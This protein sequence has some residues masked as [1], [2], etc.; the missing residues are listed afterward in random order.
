MENLLTLMNSLHEGGDSPAIIFLTKKGSQTWSFQ[1]LAS[2]SRRLARGLTKAG[3]SLGSHVILLAPN[4]PEWIVVACGLISAGI[5]PVPIDPQMGKEDLTHV[6][7]DSEAQWIFTTSFVLSILRSEQ[8]DQNRKIVLLDVESHHENS[9]QRFIAD[10][11]LPFSSVSSEDHAMLFYTSGTSGKPKGVPLTHGNL[12]SNL[13]ELLNLNLVQRNDRLLVPLP[14]HHVYPFTIGLLVSLATKI[15]LILPHSLTGPQL[16]RALREGNPTVMLG[17]PRLF[18]A[19]YSGIEKK[20]SQRGWFIA[21]GFHLALGLSI[22]LRRWFGLQFGRRIFS[23]LHREM[24]PGLQILVSGGSALSPELGWKLEGLGWRIGTGYGLTET[25]PILTL[26]KPGEGHLETA[27]TV[28]PGVDIKIAEPA[29][30][31]RHGEVLAKGPNV[32]SGYRHLPEKTREAFTNDGYFRTGDLAEWQGN[33]LKLVGRASS[34]IVLSGGENIRPDSIEEVLNEGSAI[35]ESG[36]L[37]KDDTLVALIVPATRHSTHDSR[38]GIAKQIE[39]D[40]HQHMRRLPSHHR[41]ADFAI[42]FDPLPRTRLGKLR[43]HKLAK[44]YEQAKQNKGVG[45][46]EKKGPM[47]IDQMSSEDQ[48]LVSDPQ[49]RHAWEWLS[50]RFHAIRLTPDSHVQMDLGVDSLEWVNLSVEIQDEIGVEMDQDTISR[51]E[52]VRDFLQAIAE[53]ETAGADDRLMHQL[54]DPHSLLDRTQRAWLAPLGSVERS[55]SHG[56]QKGNRW[57]MQT[58]YHVKAGG[59]EQL[60]KE[61]FILIANHVSFLDPLALAAVLPP[62]QLNNLYWAGWTEVM[63]RNFLMRGISRLAHVVPIDPQQGPFSNAAMGLACL[64]DGH[65]LGWF[66]EGRRSPDGKLQPFQSGI[67]VILEQHS[68]PVVPAWITGT[69]E[70]WPVHRRLPRRSGMISISFG[71]PLSVHEVKDKGKGDQPHQK[72]V[73]GLHHELVTLSKNNHGVG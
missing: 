7:S 8:H 6:L 56:M 17:I 51:I 71:K 48:Q 67:G 16:L 23:L 34:M 54:Q 50:S 40:V 15:P 37:E 3:L 58:V 60:P 63:F 44:L 20:V 47:P 55:L 31:S 18:E 72:I 12:S 13:H 9:W 10:S 1:Q 38:D 46:Q 35:Q 36:V 64:E 24:A 33:Y 28:L 45:E 5:V 11:D 14:F 61:P 39:Q 69:Y 30:Q 2:T 4:R 57:F 21:A 42:S 68:V 22:L 25:S 66:P 19:L 26:N 53:A 32:F 41:L 62:D 52:T 70:A 43:R 29:P 27:G 73:D 59:V 65:S 49:A